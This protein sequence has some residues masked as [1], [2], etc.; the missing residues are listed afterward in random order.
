MLLQ[1][2][3][4]NV[5]KHQSYVIDGVFLYRNLHELDSHFIDVFS[6]ASMLPEQGRMTVKIEVTF[7][8]SRAKQA[9]ASFMH[10]LSDHNL[11]YLDHAVLIEWRYETDDE[12]IEE[13]G[14]IFRDIWRNKGLGDRFKLVAI[15]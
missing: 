7:L 3:T 13:L 9:M 10:Q 6:R 12:D 2:Q 1:E 5:F 4:L 11:K 15:F 14:Q 8:V